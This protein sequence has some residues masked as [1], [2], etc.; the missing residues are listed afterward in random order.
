MATGL[1]TTCS[2]T[3][4]TPAVFAAHVR[5]RNMDEEIAAQ[6][7]ESG[8]D[9]LIGGGW[10][11]FVPSGVEGGRRKDERNLLDT[12]RARMEVVLSIEDFRELGETER[13]A[14]FFA[15]RHPPEAGKR[16]ISLAEMTE[17]AIAA[18]ARERNG[19]FLMVEGSQIDWAG[20]DG[21]APGIIAEML[22]FDEAVGVGIDFAERNGQTLVIVTS[23]HETGGYAVHDGSLT[24]SMVTESGFTSGGHTAEMV[25]IFA[26][27]PGA[28]AFGGIL[29]N[30]DIGHAMIGF[31]RDRSSRR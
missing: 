30:T 31:V 3:H 6:M 25:P 16:M 27:G 12:L 15:P 23:D 22:D 10:S 18:L 14:A 13:F 24:D 4:A 26:H 5:S 1:V 20:H 9:V 8:V 17:R 11:Y 28:K 29:D 7:T 21:D 2:I 19:F